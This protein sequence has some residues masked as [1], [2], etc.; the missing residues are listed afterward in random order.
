MRASTVLRIA[1]L[2]AGSALAS[3]SALAG[4]PTCGNGTLNA[5]EQCD[6]ANTAAGDG[7]SA[8]CT[9]EGPLDETEQ[10][11][12]GAMNAGFTGMVTYTNKAIDACLKNVS[13][14]K[15]EGTYEACLSA[16]VF[17]KPALK[18]LNANQKKCLDKGV[19][20][21]TAFGYNADPIEVATAGGLAAGDSHRGMLG[22]P[23]PVA[24]AAA[25][26]AAAKCQ[27]AVSIGVSRYLNA[28][29]K[30]TLQRKRASRKD[31]LAPPST[32]VE[33][34]AD[35]VG[36]PDA[37]VVT[38]AL[39]SAKAKAGKKCEA[40]ELAGLF[41]GSCVDSAASPST[42]VDCAAELASCEFCES[43]NLADKLLVDCSQ[44]SAF[45]SCN[46]ATPEDCGDGTEQFGEACDD[47][48]TADGDGCRADCTEEICGD[49]TPD[50]QEECDDGNTVSD[51]GCRADCTDEV[52]GDA[53]TDI[54]EA[55]DDGNTA[56]GDGCRADCTEEIC[57]D[58]TLDPQEECE[59][60]NT[61]NGD[62]CD[63]N[64]QEEFDCAT[65]GGASVAGACWFLGGD[66]A[67]CQTTCEGE[68]LVYDSATETAAGSGGSDLTCGTVLTALGFVGGTPTGGACDRGLGC[69][70]DFAI[71]P[72]PVGTS[73]RCTEPTT[74]ET[75]APSAGD[76]RACACTGT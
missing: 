4:A 62:G 63:A 19:T 52:C 41:P 47:G 66:G 55:C 17:D 12:V 40:L 50:P 13:R 59:D 74:D 39:A 14:A 70:A 22:S 5:P 56:D 6:D 11:C 64:C 27:Q 31:P 7:C 57:G 8:T 18:V 76:H 43:L 10:A 21:Q 28:L 20:A 9:I 37:P 51:D 67:S 36:A 25:D 53:T 75:S 73:Q 60:G 42:L 23:A 48:N 3:H 68:G 45:P 29:A 1:S 24:L 61:L 54:G 34:E 32:T 38:A 16:V 72:V 30:E 65:E 46:P 69:W 15:V 44:F 33:L 35:L 58:D 49:G 71:P 2:L 26:P